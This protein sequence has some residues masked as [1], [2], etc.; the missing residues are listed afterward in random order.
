[1]AAETP[2]P[3]KSLADFPKLGWYIFYICVVNELMV[4][5]LLSNLAFMIY[6]GASPK[7][8]ACGDVPLPQSEDVCADLRSI[9][10]NGS[11]DLHLEAQ[12]KS[13]GYEFGLVCEDSLLVK[14]SISLQMIGM[15]AGAA[16]LGQLSDRYGRKK[17]LTL[18][19]A[20][21][22]AS[23]IASYFS[24]S[25]LAFNITRF[26][27]MFFSGGQ[28]SSQITFIMEVVPKKHRVWIMTVLS[29][30]PN[31]I[32]LAGLAYVGEDWRNLSLYVSAAAAGAIVMLLF[33]FESPRWFIQKG[34]LEE[35]LHAVQTIDRLNGTHTVAR[36]KEMEV[37]VEGERASFES[38]KEKKQYS[39]VHLFYTWKLTGYILTLSFTLLTA[40]LLSYALLFNMDR[41]SGSI[42]LNSLFFGV[43]RWFL[44]AIVGLVDFFVPKAGRRVVHHATMGYLLLSLSVI[45]VIEV[46]DIEAPVL[47]RI[48]TLS[49]CATCSQLF[50]VAGIAA[51]ELFP[52]AIRTVAISFSQIVNK[53]GTVIAPH[54][55]TTA[56]L[57]KP[58]PYAIMIGLILF[59]VVVYCILIPE[60]KGTMNDRMPDPEERIFAKRSKEMVTLGAE[61]LETQKL[62]AEADP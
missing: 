45:F 3:K 29:T 56:L 5:V 36:A 57:W 17:I 19:I 18:S 53:I 11:C 21:V 23:M 2:K 54:L 22:M 8:V 14:N 7:I 33:V 40:S 59:E 27:A 61:D 43:L 9:R 52:T 38:Q 39:F 6:G 15:M 1:M 49:A 28:S 31:Y 55:F 30:S 26:C 48:T 12:F 24:A 44:N 37:A 10:G 16:V 47:V 25:L 35:A 46:F 62:T 41:L 32:I 50:L 51:A 42:Y 13:I 4:L 20:G 60:S 58:M 34:R